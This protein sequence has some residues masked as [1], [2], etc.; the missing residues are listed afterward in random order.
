MNQGWVFWGL[1]DSSR[2]EPDQLSWFFFVTSSAALFC[3]ELIRGTT[4][5]CRL[6]WYG[7]QVE[8]IYNGDS[9]VGLWAQSNSK[10]ILCSG[11]NTERT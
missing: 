9:G 7:R 8:S 11:A 5:L 6:R 10:I 4:S 2:P 3:T 1:T